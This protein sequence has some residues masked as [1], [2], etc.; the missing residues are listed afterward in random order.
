MRK[1]VLLTLGLLAVAAVAFLLLRPETSDRPVDTNAS[2]NA[3]SKQST[4][5]KADPRQDNK[6][7]V[8]P[9]F[10][11]F[12][13]KLDRPSRDRVTSTREDTR[14]TR[15]DDGSLHIKPAL[16]LARTLHDPSTTTQ[17]D[18]EQINAIIGLYYWIYQQN[19]VG[20]NEDIVAQLTGR[21][22]KQ[23]VVIPP[24]HPSISPDGQLLDRYGNP[25]FFHAI[26]ESKMD[27]WS[28][29][30]DGIVGTNDDFTLHGPDAL[31]ELEA[32]A[33]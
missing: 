2:G 7:P 5:N 28:Y 3:P 20:D 4:S 10:Y 18:L 19:P 11:D 30:P 29:G 17:E 12:P 8:G 27:I 22:S 31:E 1:A 24:D 6:A 25:Y 9:Q 33:E 13:E 23:V 21:N 32:E 15:T 14:F 16:D 26:S